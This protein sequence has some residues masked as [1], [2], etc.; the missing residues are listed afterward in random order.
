MVTP[1]CN[2]PINWKAESPRE[3]GCSWLSQPIW[4]KTSGWF[5]PKDPSMVCS[6]GS[7]PAIWKLRPSRFSFLSL[8]ELPPPSRFQ[9]PPLTIACEEQSCSLPVIDQLVPSANRV[10]RVEKK[11]CETI[12]I[13][14]AHVASVDFC[15]GD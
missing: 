1:R 4:T 7:T 13:R 12:R 5:N 10:P 11:P 2:L 3:F 14:R 15:D 9:Y 8:K 6:S